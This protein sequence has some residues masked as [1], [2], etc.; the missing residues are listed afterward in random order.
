MAWRVIR[1]G[2]RT[3]VKTYK[4]QYKKNCAVFPL[5]GIVSLVLSFSS[6]VKVGAVVV[7]ISERTLVV[8]TSSLMC[9]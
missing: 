8:K 7:L 2:C 5:Y 4:K 6:T 9:A 1:Q 3:K